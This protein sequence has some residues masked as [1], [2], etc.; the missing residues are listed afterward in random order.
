[1]TTLLWLRD[2]LRLADHE[3]LTAACADVR[4]AGGSVVALWIRERITDSDTQPLGAR[5]HGAATRWWYHRSLAELAPRLAGLGIPLLYAQA[6]PR[7]VV[8]R[9]AAELRASTVRWSRRYAP[10]ARSLDAA[11]KKILLSN[12][13]DAHSHPGSLLVEPWQVAPATGGHYSVFTPFHRAAED[14]PVAPLLDVPEALPKPGGAVRDALGR[15]ASDRVICTLDALAL[16][17]QNPQWWRETVERYWR[18]GEV[19]GRERLGAAAGWLAGYAEGRDMPA[20]PDSTSRLSAHLRT[21]EVSARA[22]LM[23]ARSGGSPPHDAAA[24]ARQLY[25]REFSWH[26][27]YHVAGLDRR[28]L[29]RQF[30]DFPYREDRDLLRAWRRGLTGIDLVDAGMLELWHTGWMHNRV[31]MVTASLL[32]KNMLQPWWLG[33]QWFWETLVDADEANNP[34][35]WQWVAGCGADAAPYFRVFNPDVQSRKFDPRGDYV[36]RWLS[37]RTPRRLAPVLDVKESR[38]AALDAYQGIRG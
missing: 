6:D 12:G 26:L 18:P 17:D 38:R 10:A 14:I 11:V 23:A 27:T 19:S 2:D 37:L 24:W 31:R 5:P 3:A 30:D 1:M 7:N 35:Q 33:E 8:P 16:L 4:D 15:L 25:W 13:I 36:N 29:R 21:G 22:V 34:V 32:T 9:V 20:D 28:P